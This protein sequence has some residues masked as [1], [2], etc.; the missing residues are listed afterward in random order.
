MHENKAEAGFIL[1]KIEVKKEK[2]QLLLSF[3]V[4]C[5]SAAT[6]GETSALAVYLQIHWSAARDIWRVR[7]V[8]GRF[9]DVV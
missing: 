3:M 9:K 6:G 4:Q 7:P 2:G 5:S 8:P 1:I